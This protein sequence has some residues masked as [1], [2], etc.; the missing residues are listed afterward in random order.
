MSSYLNDYGSLPCRAF[1]DPAT[2]ST[3][4]SCCILAGAKRKD[5]EH[6]AGVSG[7][8]RIAVVMADFWALPCCL[9]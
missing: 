4:R 6:Y 1:P 7:L 3:G 8:L 5:L 9:H 2:L